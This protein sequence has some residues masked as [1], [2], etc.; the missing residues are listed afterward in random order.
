[1]E[2]HID[3]RF[4]GPSD[5]ANGGYTCGLVA[6][7][8][9]G[10]AEVTLRRPPPLD[11]VLAAAWAGETLVVRDGDDVVAE[12]V[13]ASLELDV[14]EP[15]AYDEAC[16]ASTRYG[17]FRHHDFPNCFVCGP[18]RERGDGL[19]IFAGP[20]DAEDAVAA[21]WLPAAEL[22]TADSHV[23]PEIV[24]A[25]LDCPGAFAVGFG[26]RGTLLLGRLLAELRAPVRA[27]EPHVVVGW[28][29]G[30]DGR[31]FY[32]G[33]ALFSAAGDVC[34]CARATW[35]APGVL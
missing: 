1:M 15:V 4:R 33:T 24:W 20:T 12:A 13:A 31:K 26:E 30:E 34:A 29:L 21:P 11:R 9:G 5:S 35:L 3:R 23:R 14:P 18:D 10:E 25:A 27:E 6:A 22:A 7:L 17:G 8:A 32:A 2:I 16:R 28:P 19:R